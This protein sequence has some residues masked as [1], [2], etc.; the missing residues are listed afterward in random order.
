MLPCRDVRERRGGDV[1]PALGEVC[2]E[3]IVAGGGAYR[4]IA[5][6]IHLL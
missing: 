4:F 2:Q 6:C 1:L 5:Q 3:R